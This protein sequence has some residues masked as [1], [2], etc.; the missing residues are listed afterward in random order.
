MD[1]YIMYI[2]EENNMISNV[3]KLGN[4]NAIRLPKPI[5]ESLGIHTNDEVKLTIND[6]KLTIEKIGSR[7]N[8]KELFKDYSGKYEIKE[9]FD[10]KPVGRE[11]L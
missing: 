7:K 9:F 4:S 6:S 10:D 3:F 11:L 5:M 1:G 8:I 2:Q